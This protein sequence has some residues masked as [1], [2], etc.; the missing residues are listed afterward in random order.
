MNVSNERS[1]AVVHG[2]LPGQHFGNVGGKLS[3][4]EDL[5]TTQCSA[6]WEFL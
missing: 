3:A 2:A 1:L 4:E 5:S 6:E